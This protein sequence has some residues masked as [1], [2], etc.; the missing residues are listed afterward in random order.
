MEKLEKTL[1]QNLSKHLKASGKKLLLISGIKLIDTKEETSQ[2]NV[3]NY[4]VKINGK[5]HNF[6]T[7]AGRTEIYSFDN[8]ITGEGVDLRFYFMT[9]P[10]LLPRDC[11]YGFKI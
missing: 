10:R 2:Y 11:G 8:A 1:K 4:S 3:N 9:H 5:N 7:I 6:T